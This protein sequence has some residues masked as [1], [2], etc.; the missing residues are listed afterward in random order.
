MVINRKLPFLKYV[1]K[2]HV[3]NPHDGI[4]VY[5]NDS[6]DSPY[7][8]YIEISCVNNDQPFSIIL[9][10]LDNLFV[11]IGDH[12][13]A[14]EPIGEIGS[15]GHTFGEHVHVTLKVPNYGL[16]GYV[17]N[18]VVDPAPFF[19]D[20]SSLP[21]FTTQAK[22]DILPYLFPQK[23]FGPIYEVQHIHGPTETFQTQAV[24]ERGFKLVKNSQWEA[25]LYDEF[26]IYRG[27]DTSPGTCP[28][29][30]RPDENRFYIQYEPGLAYA[31]WLNRYM[32]VGDVFIGPGHLVQFHFKSDCTKSSANSGPATNRITFVA[33]HQNMLFN[34]I[35]L[36]DVIQLA[37]S[38]EK[39]FY[40]RG[41]GLVAWENSEGQR[42]GIFEIHQGRPNLTP[43]LL[44]CF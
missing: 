34:S 30:E 18:D 35:L 37:S 6:L 1:R 39:Y 9:A 42:S 26:Y 43:E 24:E 23:D 41:F 17:E 28:Y 44:N 20:P 2:V 5:R 10:H 21:L 14:G 3:L 11:Q 12:L 22:L 19:P 16:E 29:S 40:A 25:L 13:L 27:I 4:V 36:D 32:A 33:H 31:R 7:G 8:L 38:S 15:T